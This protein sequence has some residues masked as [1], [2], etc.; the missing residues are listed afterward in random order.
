MGIIGSALLAGWLAGPVWAGVAVILW[1]VGFGLVLQHWYYEMKP[2]GVLLRDQVAIHLVS[3]WSEA[4]RLAWIALHQ[5]QKQGTYPLIT[6]FVDEH[7]DTS[8][9]D[10]AFPKDQITGWI[11][12]SF[13]LSGYLEIASITIV[14]GAVTGLIASVSAIYPGIQWN[15]SSAIDFG[16][17]VLLATISP[18]AITLF[19]AHAWHNLT[20]K[21]K[22]TT[23]DRPGAADDGT[24]L[25]AE[26]RKAGIKENA[27]RKKFFLLSD[28]ASKAWA[29]VQSTRRPGRELDDR[30]NPKYINAMRDFDLADSRFRD[31][32]QALL[33]ADNRSTL[34][35]NMLDLVEARAQVRAIEARYAGTALDQP[36]TVPEDLPQAKEK[37]DRLEIHVRFLSTHAPPAGE[38]DTLA[39][40]ETYETWRP[41]MRSIVRPFTGWTVNPGV[42]ASDSE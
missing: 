20:N 19:A 3:W 42:S 21:Y 5:F 31:A 1:T 26:I 7:Y 41:R 37:A 17:K 34:L 30:E 36:G 23:G 40:I 32:G 38:K 28:K 10:P 27:A 18:V 2:Q 13:H 4:P 15:V 35:R 6:D 33:R 39:A 24:R 12:R 14:I 9:N 16:A 22:L 29:E 8:I 11:D 25:R